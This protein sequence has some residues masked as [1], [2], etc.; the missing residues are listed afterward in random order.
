GSEFDLRCDVSGQ[1]PAGLHPQALHDRADDAGLVL[2]DAR[3]V[4]LGEPIPE[5]A[6]LAQ[7]RGMEGARLHRGHAESA[8]PRTHLPRRLRC[9]GQGQNLVGREHLGG[10]S[11]GDAVRHGSGLARSGTGQDDHRGV[12][13]GGDLSLLLVQ[14]LEKGRGRSVHALSN[15]LWRS[16]PAM[17]TVEGARTVFAAIASRSSSRV[18]HLRVAIS[19]RSAANSR[20]G[21]SAENP[22]MSEHG[23][24]HGWDPRYWGSVTSRWASSQ[25]SLI[26]ARSSVSPRSTK[27]ASS[28]CRS[29][30]DA[31]L[32]PIG[33]R[34][35]PSSSVL[36]MTTM[37]AGSVRGRCSLPVSGSRRTHPPR[38]GSVG[39]PVRGEYWWAR[40]QLPTPTTSQAKDTCTSSRDSANC[41][42]GSHTGSEL[43]RPSPGAVSRSLASRAREASRAESRRL[44]PA[45]SR[46]TPM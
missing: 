3:E 23:K 26:T 27:P 11:V 7:G 39:V 41:R 30:C 37:T 4:P 32:L 40:C 16:W 18:N 25:I 19:V 22:S 33:S 6:Q 24:G 15:Q 29:A 8:Q 5:E 2:D 21:A 20:L 36:T 34:S 35:T 12:E 14:G 42:R 46:D 17:E 10:D 38:A 9:E 43:S 44:R 31:A 28:G 1:L 13:V 45:S